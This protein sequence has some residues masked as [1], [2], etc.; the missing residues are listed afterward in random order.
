MIIF[1]KMLKFH[2]FNLNQD[3]VTLCG[4]LTISQN[5]PILEFGSVPDTD[6]LSALYTV[7][8]AVVVV[9]VGL[10]GVDSGVITV[11]SGGV[12][13]VDHT[14]AVERLAPAV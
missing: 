5:L 7:E 8:A 11:L 6:V 14:A 9:V 1:I 3:F 13:E 10:S 4:V 2:S 12:S